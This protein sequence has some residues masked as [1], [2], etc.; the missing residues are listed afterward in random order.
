M[1]DFVLRPSTGRMPVPRGVRQ[2][3]A[4]RMPFPLR[5]PHLTLLGPVNR[6][7][8]NAALN[9]VGSLSYRHQSRRAS[10]PGV[11]TADLVVL[12]SYYLQQKALAAGSASFHDQDFFG[13]RSSTPPYHEVPQPECAPHD[14]LGFAHTPGPREVRPG[15]SFRDAETIPPPLFFSPPPS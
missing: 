11:Q 1:W 5:Q 8:L 3:R 14:P 7:L 2:V 12:D 15:R 9:P 6:T 10:L 13:L 4:P